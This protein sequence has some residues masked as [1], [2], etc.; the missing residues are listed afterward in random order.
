ML[1]SRLTEI[2]RLKKELLEWA[3]ISRSKEE[4]EVAAGQLLERLA[5]NYNIPTDYDEAMRVWRSEPKVHPAFESY[6]ERGVQISPEEEE[7]ILANAE[8]CPK[9]GGAMKDVSRGEM[10]VSRCSR[11]RWVDPDSIA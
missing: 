3:V 10:S 7:E 1:F 9:C 11:C 2:G 5:R 4:R 8:Y 6:A